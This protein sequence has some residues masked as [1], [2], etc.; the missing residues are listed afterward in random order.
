VRSQQVEGPVEQDAGLEIDP[1]CSLDLRT[2]QVDEPFSQS[3]MGTAEPGSSNPEPSVMT[4]WIA[5]SASPMTVAR[6]A[7]NWPETA[8][9]AIAPNT[10]DP[11]PPHL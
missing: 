3:R 4:A 5:A 9:N 10:L 11:T 2:E 1:A 6:Q 8:G 7:P